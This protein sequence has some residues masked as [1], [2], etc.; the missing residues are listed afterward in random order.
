LDRGKGTGWAAWEP[1]RSR[2]R[3]RERAPANRIAGR[4]MILARG[5]GLRLPGSAGSSEHEARRNRVGPGSETNKRPGMRGW[6]V[7]APS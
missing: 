2:S 4:T 1:E 5:G 6:E 7:V 3:P